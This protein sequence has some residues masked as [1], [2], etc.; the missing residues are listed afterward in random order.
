M[1]PRARWRALPGPVLFFVLAACSE[2]D[3]GAPCHLL[4]ADGS[5]LAPP[6]GH[7]IVQ[8]GSG[9]CEQF[10]CVSFNG[11][12]PACSRP[13]TNSGSD[14]EAGWKCRP[15]VLDPTS[16]TLVR[17]RTE[18]R[19]EDRN[20]VDDYQQLVAGTTDSLYCGPAP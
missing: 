19:D 7:D 4:R 18:G 11:G 12:A 3:L 20:G 9:E 17:E 15:L 16:L 1:S 8:S 13:C 6:A 2:T 10:A 14:C 5:E